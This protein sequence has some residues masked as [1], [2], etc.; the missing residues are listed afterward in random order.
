M[1]GTPEVKFSEFGEFSIGSFCSIAEGLTI[2]LGGEHNVNNITTYPFD[3]RYGSEFTDSSS[4]TKGN[5]TIGNDVWIGRN[6]TIL[7]GVTVNHGAVIG[8]ESIVRNS[9]HP[10]WIVA[11]NPALPIRCR[12]EAA[13]V[14][15]LLKMKWWDWPEELIMKASKLLLSNNFAGLIKYWE[16][17]VGGK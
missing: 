16:D 1:V 12:F 3:V 5:V 9:I 14:M 11:G 6:V 17:S 8:A 13:E 7:S 2:L 4:F 10:Y 15:L